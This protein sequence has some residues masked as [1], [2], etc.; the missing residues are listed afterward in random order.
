MTLALLSGVFQKWKL[1]LILIWLAIAALNEFFVDGRALRLLFITEFGPFFAAGLLVHHIHAHGRSPKAL[2]LL[3]AAFL[4][5]CC[6]LSVTQHWMLNEY[7]M[8]VS[9]T[10]LV[11]A[12]VVMHTALIGG[13]LLRN[14]VRPSALTL[15]LGGLTYPLYL[16]HQNI[17]YL[18]INAAAPLVGK[19]TAALGCVALML[20][21]SWVIWRYFER[22]VQR[23][24]KTWFGRAVE[25][26]LGR[27]RPASTD[28]QPAE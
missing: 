14:R 23:A 4:L 11:A 6:T 20:L 1:E 16:L 8:A 5:S 21:A 3:A 10:H 9:Q 25:A 15:A 27:F 19:W 7:G 24:L 17:G 13:V 26:A 12:N 28:A 2:L 22:P 18:A